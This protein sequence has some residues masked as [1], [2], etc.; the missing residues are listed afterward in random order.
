MKYGRCTIGCS[1]SQTLQRAHF[2]LP[3][4]YRNVG[5]VW[6]R[7][8]TNDGRTHTPH[9][10][11]HWNLVQKTLVLWTEIFSGKMV[12]QGPIFSVKM[13]RP[14]KFAN[15][16]IYTPKQVVFSVVGVVGVPS[17]VGVV[18]LPSVVVGTVGTMYDNNTYI[19]V[20]V[21]DC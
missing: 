3:L 18:V 9:V 6:E 1:C 11:C 5:W 12:P 14:W 2:P 10:G 7:D 17:V 20:L 19:H 21:L 15:M 13:V 4:N 16:S 8:Y